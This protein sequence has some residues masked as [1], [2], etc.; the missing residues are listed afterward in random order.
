MEKKII[1]VTGGNSGIG[2]ETAVTLA[3]AGHFVILH[4]RDKEKTKKV[5]EEIKKATPLPGLMVF[6]RDMRTGSC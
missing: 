1:L 2:K 3:K 5:Y 6:L 4:G